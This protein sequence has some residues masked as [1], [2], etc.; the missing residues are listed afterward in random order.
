VGLHFGSCKPKIRHDGVMEYWSDGK[1][2]TSKD[3]IRPIAPLLHYS[4]G[5]RSELRSA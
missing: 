1:H 5:E 4:K 2:R 3:P